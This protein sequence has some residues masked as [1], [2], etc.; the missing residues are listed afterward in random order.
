[1]EDGLTVSAI[2][3]AIFAPLLALAVSVLLIV[4]LARFIAKRS[5]RSPA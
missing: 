4:L 5:R 2:V 1:V 3:I